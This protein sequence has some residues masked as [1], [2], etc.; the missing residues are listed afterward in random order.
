MQI[1]IIGAAARSRR[2]A[3]LG[4]NWLAAC[5]QRAVRTSRHPGRQHLGRPC[6]GRESLMPDVSFTELPGRRVV[7]RRFRPEDV[8]DFVTYRSDAEVARYQSWD[9][10]Y[11]AE[12]GER[13]VRQMMTA[14][15]DTPGEWFQFAVALRVTGQLIGDCAAMPRADDPSQCEIGFTIAPRYQGRGYA[16]EA[17]RL[18]AGYLFGRASTGSLPAAM[19]GMRHRPPC[20]SGWPC[21]GRATCDRAPGPRAGGPMTCS[22]PCCDRSGKPAGSEPARRRCGSRT[23]PEIVSQP[24]AGPGRSHA[25]RTADLNV[26]TED[27]SRSAGRP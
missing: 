23:G 7:V 25:R 5:Y 12:Q 24:E 20:W 9:A 19:R 17:V 2:C 22:T 27:L 4:L 11:P 18:L 16:T 15:P 6:G 13:F 21:G 10:P 1:R 8:A 14:H 3:R 26:A